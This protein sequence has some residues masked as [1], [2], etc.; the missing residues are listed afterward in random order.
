VAAA[1][2]IAVRRAGRADGP[3]LAALRWAW[4]G[5][6]GVAAHGS[7]D[8]FAVDFARWLRSRGA[9]HRPVIAVRGAEPVGMGWLAVVERVPD[10]DRPERRAGLVQTV[11]VRAADRGD[12]VG[13]KIVSEILRMASSGSLDYLEVHPSPASFSF[14]RRLGFQGSDQTL[15]LDLPRVSPAAARR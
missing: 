10:V 9:G 13:A 4:A 11:F 7:F 5:E 2:E 14:Y 8:R 12:G 15:R 6:R 1:G 3:A